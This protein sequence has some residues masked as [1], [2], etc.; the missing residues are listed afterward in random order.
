MKKNLLK[1]CP[2]CG[3][4]LTISKL[5]CTDCDMEYSGNFQTSFFS[6]LDDAEIEFIKAFLKNEGNISKMQNES[7]RTYANIKAI[8]NKINI[9]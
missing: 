7:G 2:V 9:K 6:M 1:T 3:K 8:L 4:Y 5:K